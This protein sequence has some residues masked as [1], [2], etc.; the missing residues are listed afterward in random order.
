MVN[1]LKVRGCGFRS[2]T[3]AIDTA[4]GELVFHLFGAMVQF[5]RALIVERT[6]RQ[7]EHAC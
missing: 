3:K 4:N 1:D 2:L 5:E 6:P 7:V